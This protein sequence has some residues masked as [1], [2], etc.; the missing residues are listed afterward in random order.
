M[1][2]EHREDRIDR[3]TR[4]F[5]LTRLRLW[6][7]LGVASASVAARA[8]EVRPPLSECWVFRPAHPPEP[9]W[10]HPNP[11]PVGGWYGTNEL[12]RV[13]FDDAYHVT[14]AAAGGAVYFGSSADGKVYALDAATGK[15][16]WSARTGGPV[17]LRRPC[18]ATR[19]MSGPTT[20]L[21]I[22]CELATERSSGSSARST[23][24]KLLGSGKMISRWPIRTGVLV[25][26]G[27]AYFGAGD[28]SGRGV[29]RCMRSA[30]DGKLIWRNDTC[31][32]GAPE[33][34]FAAGLS[35]RLGRSA[36]RAAG[37]GLTGRLR[38]Q[39]RPPAVRSLH[40]AH[41]RRR[42]VHALRLAAFH[43]DR[44]AD[45]LR[46][47]VAPLPIRLVL[48][49]SAGGDPRDVLR[50][51]GA[52]VVRRKPCDLWGRQPAP[53]G[54][55]RPQTSPH[56]GPPGGP[57]GAGIATPAASSRHGRPERGS[58]AR[59]NR[60]WPAA[61]SGGSPASATIRSFWRATSFSPAAR[62]VVAFDASSGDSPWSAKV[63]GKARG[64]AIAE[65]RLF[66][67]SASA[68]DPLVSA[69][70]ALRQ[71]G[72]SRRGLLRRLSPG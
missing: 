23:S 29:A 72:R 48:G 17:R 64:L 62:S 46:R 45:R 24:R 37:A 41:H 19:S 39:G 10:G 38:S 16:R 67:S 40:R 7:G 70:R 68:R 54:T 8:G 43:R 28:L 33:P 13:H 56:P 55:A 58:S 44:R 59:P 66:V 6:A 51:D 63:G 14:A 27:V 53:Q 20:V 12:P 18:S 22:A 31:G 50:G 61:R 60:R 30:D 49:A 3:R 36:V 9:A 69:P 32:E 34:D 26:E 21:S 25:D 11:R 57:P 2:S 4:R 71:S 52:R 1:A 65:S 42:H 47:G 35:A 5:R 15:E